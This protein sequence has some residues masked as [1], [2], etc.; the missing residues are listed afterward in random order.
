MLQLA[1][2]SKKLQRHIAAAAKVDDFKELVDILAN[3]GVEVVHQELESSV[4]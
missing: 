1:G 4:A 2:M 3:L